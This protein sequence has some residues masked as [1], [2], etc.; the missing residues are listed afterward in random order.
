MYGEADLQRW[1][2]DNAREAQEDRARRQRDLYPPREE[3]HSP[4]MVNQTSAVQAAR[5][6]QLGLPPG[7]LDD[8]F[9]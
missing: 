7:T 9:S 5:E 2:Q 1:A 3:V 6:H 4:L 8:I